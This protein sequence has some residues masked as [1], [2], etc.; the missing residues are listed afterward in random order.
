MIAPEP[1][2]NVTGLVHVAVPTAMVAVPSVRPK[3]N[4]AQPVL[5]LLISAAVKFTVPAPP[6]K[7]I[8]V[9]ALACDTV[10]VPVPVNAFA[11]ASAKLPSVVIFVADDPA[12][13]IAPMEIIPVVLFKLTVPDV[14]VIAP[15]RFIPPVP[16]SKANV[17]VDCEIVPVTVCV[18]PTVVT[19]KLFAPIV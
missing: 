12:F 18:P 5:M 17:P 9:P 13:K 14:L 3:I 16:L 7:P 8:V 4:D 1:L 6:P 19:V 15:F 2:R 11:T 10:S